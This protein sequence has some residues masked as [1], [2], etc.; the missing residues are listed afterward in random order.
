MSKVP[1]KLGDL[2]ELLSSE[3]GKGYGKTVLVVVKW[4]VSD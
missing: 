3:R 1:C 2:D 4:N